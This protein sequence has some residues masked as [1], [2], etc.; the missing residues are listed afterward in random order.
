MKI[1]KPTSAKERIIL[2]LDV[3]DIQI[4]KNIVIE[5]RDYVGFFKVGLQLFTSCGFD[6]IKMKT[7][8]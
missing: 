3:D 4:A 2:A 8:I 6:A 1:S 7:L 5:L